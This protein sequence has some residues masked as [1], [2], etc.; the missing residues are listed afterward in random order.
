MF[1]WEGAKPNFF[2]GTPPYTHWAMAPKSH[3]LAFKGWNA[4]NVA[5]HWNSVGGGADK[6]FLSFD[7]LAPSQWNFRPKETL[8]MQQNA[9][10]LH[11]TPPYVALENDAIFHIIWDF[12]NF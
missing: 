2:I 7:M 12:T 4:S 10:K 8:E 6:K 9:S 5:T 3:L 11:I 1:D